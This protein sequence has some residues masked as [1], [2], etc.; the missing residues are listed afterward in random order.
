MKYV[1]EL[2]LF[3]IPF[4]VI[5]SI[6]IYRDVRRE[7][8]G[9]YKDASKP[10]FLRYIL[11]I[12]CLP[13]DFTIG[14]IDGMREKRLCNLLADQNDKIESLQVENKK[15]KK[16][17]KIHEDYEQ[18]FRAFYRPLVDSSCLPAYDRD[19]YSNYRSDYDLFHPEN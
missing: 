19:T 1:L 11:K 4:H 8:K 2:I 5:E 12:L 18:R 13:Y 17:I 7:D 14:I 6:L 9:V 3:S 16:E 15:L 10:F